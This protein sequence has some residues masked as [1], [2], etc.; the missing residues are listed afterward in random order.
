MA[1]ISGGRRWV[2]ESWWL[3]V[4]QSNGTVA[5]RS[6]TRDLIWDNGQMVNLVRCGVQ[7]CERAKKCLEYRAESATEKGGGVAR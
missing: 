4:R 2:H 7:T 1:S 3:I 5:L 6:L